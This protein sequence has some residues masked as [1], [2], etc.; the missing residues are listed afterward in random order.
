MH[1]DVIIFELNTHKRV[2][3]DEKRTRGKL[4][5]ILENKQN[6]KYFRMHFDR[7][8]VHDGWHSLYF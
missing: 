3:K 5:R 8:C 4:K 6:M 1:C 7:T 2:C